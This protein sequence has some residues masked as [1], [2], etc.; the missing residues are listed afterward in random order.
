VSGVGGALV[1]NST[2]ARLGCRVLV[3]QLDLHFGTD[4]SGLD[5]LARAQNCRARSNHPPASLDLFGTYGACSP[6]LRWSTAAMLSA[7][8]PTVTPAG[9][10]PRSGDCEKTTP[11]LQLVD[12]GY[13]EGSGVGTLADLAPRL[14]A[15]V[16]DKNAAAGS[17]GPFVVPLVAYLED[18]VRSDVRVRPPK[19]PPE[20]LVPLR[21]TGAKKTLGSTV[22]QLQRVAT[23]FA[24]PCPKGA[25]PACGDLARLVRSSIP[26]G[27]LLIAPPTEPSVTAPLGWTLS[28]DSR[29]QLD[30]ALRYQACLG[31][32][33][34]DTYAGLG[35]LLDLLGE[36]ASTR[37]PPSSH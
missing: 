6:Q 24:S 21:A 8:F 14:S 19:D 22:A 25:D 35:P 27:V 4:T 36:P 17:T 5:P 11:D 9:R 2:D 31:P 30:R 33:R 10:V 13:A 28:R 3:S 32:P 1:L 34:D 7:R 29:D 15:L 20:V 12:G 18:E 26:D 37:C 16:R 23:A